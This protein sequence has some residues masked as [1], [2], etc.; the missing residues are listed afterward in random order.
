MA[1]QSVPSRRLSPDS[2]FDQPTNVTQAK[3]DKRFSAYPKTTPIFQP[4]LRLFSVPLAEPSI[5]KKPDIQINH[6]NGPASAVDEDVSAARNGN[7][8]KQKQESE[9]H[10]QLPKQNCREQK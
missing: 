2:L 10:K 4:A 3:G 6:S 9:S 8:P 7:I 1:Q 5:L